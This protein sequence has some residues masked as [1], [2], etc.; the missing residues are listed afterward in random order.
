M[1]SCVLVT[2][3]AVRNIEIYI[4][5]YITLLKTGRLKAVEVKSL[6]SYSAIDGSSTVE[7]KGKGAVF[8]DPAVEK[9]TWPLT[10]LLVSARSRKI[11]ALTHHSYMA[12]WPDRDYAEHEKM[13]TYYLSL[14]EDNTC[15]KS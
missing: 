6:I 2:Q 9:D 13:N 1:R 3:T 15:M 10:H 12:L 5:L 8:S 14:Q 7:E 11:S 4:Y